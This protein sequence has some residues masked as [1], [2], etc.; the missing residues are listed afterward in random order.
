V[1]RI[2][3]VIPTRDRPLLL[4]RAVASVLAQVGVDVEVVVVDDGSA[5]PVELR[6]DARVRIVRR[7]HPDGPATARN[8]GLAE[9]SEPWVAFLDDDDLWAPDKLALQLQALVAAPDAGWVATGATLADA[10][11]VPVRAFPPPSVPDFRR[12]NRL[13][14]GAS[15]VLARTALVRDL[16]GF[17]PAFA[18]LEDWDLWIRLAAAAPLA[19][20]D[21]PLVT[22]VR[23][24]G[25]RSHDAVAIDEALP[26]LVSK[27]GLVE[28]DR[29]W[30][31]L[32]SGE[33]HQRA[34]HRRSAAHRYLQAA[35][36]FHEPR[37]LLR[38]LAAAAWPGS[39][40]L[41]DDRARGRAA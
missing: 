2:S 36:A 39:I 37:S 14:A 29:R 30:A 24:A 8:A 16:G 26:R 31:L 12:R 22:Y 34:G 7:G 5:V 10:A 6:G 40:R 35:W 4:E 1:Q 41:R 21:R 23:V 3:V 20:V 27:H 13:I 15:S 25:G 28:L 38:A 18:V 19:V 33:M 11:L 9:V 32:Y 17:D